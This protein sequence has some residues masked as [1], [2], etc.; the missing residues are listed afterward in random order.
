M[1]Q[2]VVALVDGRTQV[3]SPVDDDNDPPTEDFRAA[4][5]H[6]RSLWNVELQTAK[7]KAKPMTRATSAPVPLS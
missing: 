2:E 4:S 6:F 3:L 1:W 5:E 7:S